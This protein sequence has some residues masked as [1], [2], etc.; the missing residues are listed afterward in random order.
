[1]IEEINQRTRTLHKLERKVI[2]EFQQYFFYVSREDVQN[3]WS[4]LN[5][6]QAQFVQIISKKDL[7]TMKVSNDYLKNSGNEISQIEEIEKLLKEYSKS[8]L[9]FSQFLHE[10]VKEAQN[11]YYNS[12]NQYKNAKT[13]NITDTISSGQKAIFQFSQI[14]PL[15]NG[16]LLASNGHKYQ[17]PCGCKW[18]IVEGD[19]L[20]FHEKGYGKII[21]E[22]V[23][24]PNH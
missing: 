21:E 4:S 18:S 3:I 12:G 8:E 6:L 2:E 5:K 22:Y 1:M 11:K 16:W 7:G 15:E 13:R 10:V 23:P 24:A 14:L 17:N 19:A 20:E 9:K